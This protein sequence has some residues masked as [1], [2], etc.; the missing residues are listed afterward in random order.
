[1]YKKILVD[2]KTFYIKD[3]KKDF[4]CQYGYIKAKDLTKAKD[5]ETLTTNTGKKLTILSPSFVDIYRKIKRAAQIIPLKDLGAIIANT[6]INSNSKVLDAGSGSGGLCCFLAHIAKKVITYD[7]RQDHI[8][9]V[10]KNIKLLG[11][12]NIK[13]EKKDIYE[14]I[15]EKN[16]DLITLD[17]PEPW[18]AL[19]NASKALKI[20]GFIV[21]YSPSIPQVM[22]FVNE[23]NKSK[24]L[25]HLKTIEIIERE[26]ELDGR[27]I[28][29]KSQPIGHSG[30]LSFARRIK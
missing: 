17:L 1:M 22:D 28:R 20:G 25:I 9:I 19:Q 29:P 7:I 4:H 2:K 14:K 18:K 24:N 16:I 23:V 11:L 5:G 13:A 3:L 27:R 15:D 8:D 30:F 12:K 6:G 10:K 21:S 26:W